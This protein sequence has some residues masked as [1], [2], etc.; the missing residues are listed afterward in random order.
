M[1]ILTQV[2][3]EKIRYASDVGQYVQVAWIAFEK[4]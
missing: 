2:T 1:E 4:N 3:S